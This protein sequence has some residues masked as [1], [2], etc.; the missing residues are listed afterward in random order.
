MCYYY[1]AWSYI[2]I[3]ILYE[4]YCI[5]L[6][7]LLELPLTNIHCYYVH[8]RIYVYYIATYILVCRK[9]GRERKRERERERE[10]VFFEYVYHGKYNFM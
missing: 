9:R 8:T 10:R 2:I 4:K 1:Y 7:V 5:R 3:I 6:F